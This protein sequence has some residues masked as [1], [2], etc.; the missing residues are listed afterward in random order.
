E[1]ETTDEHRYTQIENDHLCSSVFIGGFI[2]RGDEKWSNERLTCCLPR[3]QPAPPSRKHVKV[4]R[5]VRSHW[6]RRFTG[7]VKTRISY[8]ATACV[9]PST[10]S[11][12]ND[13]PAIRSIAR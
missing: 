13:G 2:F 1:N 5:P 3:L 11:L 9:M 8:S 10:R 12:T 4:C 6:N 7:Q